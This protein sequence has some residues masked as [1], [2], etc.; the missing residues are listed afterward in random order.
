VLFLL[1]IASVIAIVAGV[2]SSDITSNYH[3]PVG[4]ITWFGKVPRSH[5]TFLLA[6]PNCRLIYHYT[7]HVNLTLSSICIIC[8]E[9]M[10]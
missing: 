6:L 4:Y 5:F 3:P 8:L 2:I 9:K 1:T 7:S 10:V